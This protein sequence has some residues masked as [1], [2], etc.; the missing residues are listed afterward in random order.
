MDAYALKSCFHDDIAKPGII[1]KSG[2]KIFDK[3]VCAE[4]F[5]LSVKNGVYLHDG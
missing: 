1:N 2:F 4:T 3:Q 5:G